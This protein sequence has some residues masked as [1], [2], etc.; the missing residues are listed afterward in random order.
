MEALLIFSTSCLKLDKPT[1]Q[2]LATHYNYRK[3]EVKGIFSIC[4]PKRLENQMI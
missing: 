1:I 3:N 4:L 2:T